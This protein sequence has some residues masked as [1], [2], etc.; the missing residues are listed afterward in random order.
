MR[1]TA[2]SIGRKCGWNFCDAQ[3]QQGCFDHHLGGELHAGC[4]QCHAFVG[5]LAKGSQPTIEVPHR[6]FKKESANL[7]ERGISKILMQGRHGVFLDPAAKAVAHHQ[8]GSPAQLLK[9]TGNVAEIVAIVRVA[10]QNI[11]A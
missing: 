10:H 1:R 7:S 6:T 8:V 4:S 9:K 5:V 3:L 11:L 2:A